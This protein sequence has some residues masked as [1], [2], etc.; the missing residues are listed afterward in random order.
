MWKIILTLWLIYALT[1]NYFLIRR[2]PRTKRTAPPT[3]GWGNRTRVLVIGATGGTG[4]KLVEQALEQGQKVTAFVRKP[5]KLKIEHENLR[6]VQGNVMDPASL[7][8]AMEGQSVVLSALGHKRFLW[9]TRILS[10]G[11]ENI[12][13]AMKNNRVPRL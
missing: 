5:A 7:E 3:R 4:R 6:V 12:M 13:R 1:Y 8:K 2:A 10:R 9:P 11:T